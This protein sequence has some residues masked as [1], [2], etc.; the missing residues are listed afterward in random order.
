MERLKTIIA[1][2]IKFRIAIIVSSAVPSVRDFGLLYAVTVPMALITD[3]FY[4]P[5]LLKKFDN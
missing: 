3:I 1:T 4:L 2:I 5:G